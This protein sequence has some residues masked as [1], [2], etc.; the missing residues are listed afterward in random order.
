MSYMFSNGKAVMTADSVVQWNLLRFGGFGYLYTVM[1]LKIPKRFLIARSQLLY[2][3][4]GSRKRRTI[5]KITKIG[6]Y[7][8]ERPSH[9]LMD[10]ISASDRR[11]GI[12]F[13]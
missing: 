9:A 11:Y 7:G 12:F 1:L 5:L 6:T 13:F 2:H 10:S 4:C 8:L 3:F